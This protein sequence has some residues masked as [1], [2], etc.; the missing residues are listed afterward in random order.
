M[1]AKSTELAEEVRAK[2]EYQAETGRLVR[3]ARGRG[4][5][6]GVEVGSIDPETGHRRAYLAGRNRM[7][8]HLVWAHHYGS[9]P[10]GILRH[11]NGD[12][13]DDRIE[14]LEVLKKQLTKHQ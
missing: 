3:V 10:S 5:K 2:F 4:A 14:N 9:L 6:V 7:T 12:N 1:I 8:A 11:K 13:S